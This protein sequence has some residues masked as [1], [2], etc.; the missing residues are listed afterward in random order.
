MPDFS[1]FLHSFSF[2]LSLPTGIFAPMGLDWILRRFAFALKMSLAL[3]CILCLGFALSVPS[4]RTSFS[5]TKPATQ[6]QTQAVLPVFY[7]SFQPYAL[8]PAFSKLAAGPHKRELG[9]L[10]LRYGQ[11]AAWIAW[12]NAAIQKAELPNPKTMAQ[13]YER[14][15]LARTLS[16]LPDPLQHLTARQIPWQGYLPRPAFHSCNQFRVWMFG[17]SIEQKGLIR[18]DLGFS[19]SNRLPVIDLVRDA[20]ANTLK[21]SIPSMLLGFV[22]GLLL[23]LFAA[24]RRWPSSPFMLLSILPSF[25]MGAFVFLVFD[26]GGTA[27]PAS[28]AH[29]NLPS[30][31]LAYKLPLIALTLINTAIFAAHHQVWIQAET[32]QPF[33]QTALAKGLSPFRALSMHALRAALNLVVAFFVQRLPLL[34]SGTVVIEVMFGVPGFGRLA[35][36]AVLE[37]DQPLVLGCLL[38]AALFAWASVY[39]HSVFS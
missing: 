7:L 33:F 11:E 37:N 4:T 39:L 28:A 9:K 10:M 13:I 6:R 27:T 23:A 12:F 22:L 38:L 5:E 26:W 14:P 16:F 36:L 31:L 20:A 21:F 35:W 3:F 1:A 15:E 2:L 32:H 17:R 19:Q 30:F 34:I 25:L 8:P 29:L 18:G 24:H